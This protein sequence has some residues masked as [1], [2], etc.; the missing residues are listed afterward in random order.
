M[1][2]LLF[3]NMNRKPLL[4]Q[5]VN[6][7]RMHDVSLMALAE[8]HYPE[9]LLQALNADRDDDV[10]YYAFPGNNC[11]ITIFTTMTSL[12]FR[13]LEMAT[14][15][16][17]DSWKTESQQEIIFVT[18]HARSSLR[19]GKS[20]Q[21]D[22]LEQLARRIELVE[23]ER[24]HTRTVLMGDLN[25]QP[26]DSR[27]TMAKGLH[28]VMSREVAKRLSRSVAGKE[29][30][31]FYNPGW[32]FFANRHPQPQGTYYYARAEQ[33]VYF[34]YIHDQILIRPALLNCLN[35]DDV[36]ILV[37]DGVTDLGGHDG[38]PDGKRVSDH[39]PLVATMNFSEGRHDDINHT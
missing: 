17:I 20:D 34:W 38:R 36:N 6:L 2:T 15:Y 4:Q 35:D 27:V 5:C 29:Y 33:N 25:A 22:E 10:Q 39:F 7:A 8:C 24:G 13:N 30:R 26:F 32:K 3:W 9:E 18:A 28:A 31:Y 11:R 23:N 16:R 1:L 19:T 14:R 12:Y 21:A 37:S